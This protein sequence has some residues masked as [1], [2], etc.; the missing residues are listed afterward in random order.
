MKKYDRAFAEM[1]SRH[2]PHSRADTLEG[3]KPILYELS[4]DIKAW[5]GDV[6][7]RVYLLMQEIAKDLDNPA[8]AR[9][10]LGL[11]FLIL[12]KGGN[13]ALE[14]ARPVFNEKILKMYQDPSYEN[15]RFLPRLMLLLDGY[16]SKHIEKLTKE[17]IHAWGDERFRAAGDFLGLEELEE[18]S[19]RN[20]IKGILGGE[21]A[22]A[23]NDKDMTA[24]NRA[25][26]LY[27]AV[28]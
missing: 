25:V 3:M 24:L 15:E 9:A 14:M 12:S 27:H 23:G 18:R 20:R 2:G 4:P 28:K 22:K 5:T 1:V 16:D 21:I 13:S 8:S 6:R 19:L 10:S 17:A 26:E 7:I 11:L